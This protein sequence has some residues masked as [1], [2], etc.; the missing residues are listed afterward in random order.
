LLHTI[1]V[2]IDGELDRTPVGSDDPAFPTLVRSRYHRPIVPDPPG[3][4]IFDL[5]K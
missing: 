4:Q 3:I 1:T 2:G 5:T